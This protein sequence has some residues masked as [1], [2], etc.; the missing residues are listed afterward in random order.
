MLN[1]IK[2]MKFESYEELMEQFHVDVPENFNFAY[3][4]FDQIAKETE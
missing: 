4:V 1:Y 3:D 2:N